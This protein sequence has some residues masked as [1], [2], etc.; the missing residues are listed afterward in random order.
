MCL[1]SGG[2]FRKLLYS[3]VLMAGTA[4]LCYPYQAVKLAKAEYQWVN[5]KIGLD[6]AYQKVCRF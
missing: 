1:Q 5:S 4:S 6:E 2:Y 3:S